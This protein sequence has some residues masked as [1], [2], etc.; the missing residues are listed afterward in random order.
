MNEWRR[1]ASDAYA[2]LD[3]LANEAPAPAHLDA[4]QSARCLG[5]ALRKH[6]RVIGDE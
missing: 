5:A 4:V 1:E 2:T 6:D 3:R